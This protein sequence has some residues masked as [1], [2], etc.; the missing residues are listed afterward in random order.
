MRWLVSDIILVAGSDMQLPFTRPPQFLPPARKCSKL[1]F[2]AFVVAGV[3]LR[4]WK[5]R[6][7]LHVPTFPRP[8]AKKLVCRQSDPGK[9]ERGMQLKMQPRHW[10]GTWKEPEKHWSHCCKWNLWKDGLKEERE[11]A[12]PICRLRRIRLRGFALGNGGRPAEICSN[13]RR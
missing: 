13:N 12:R 4:I 2:T 3:Q 6:D 8:Q 11:V 1:H 9:G 5:G 7:R 10:A